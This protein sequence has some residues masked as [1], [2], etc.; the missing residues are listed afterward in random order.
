LLRAL[1]HPMYNI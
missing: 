1:T